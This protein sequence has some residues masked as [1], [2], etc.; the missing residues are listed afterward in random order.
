MHSN[1][2]LLTM[3]I[4]AGTVGLIYNIL[5]LPCNIPEKKVVNF[6]DLVTFWHHNR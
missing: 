1:F 6:V 3:L 5:I 4:T 2:F